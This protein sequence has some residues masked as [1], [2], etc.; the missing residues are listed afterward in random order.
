M[1][2]SVTYHEVI[3]VGPLSKGASHD[4]LRS[5]DGACPWMP[6]LP[7]DV[8]LDELR[9]V[10]RRGHGAGKGAQPPHPMIPSV[11]G[12]ED[13]FGTEYRL[14]LQGLPIAVNTAPLQAVGQLAVK[15]PGGILLVALS[16]S[17]YRYLCVRALTERSLNATGVL[18]EESDL[19]SVSLTGAGLEKAFSDY[20]EEYGRTDVGEKVAKDISDYIRFVNASF[21][22]YD[23]PNL[24]VG[25]CKRGFRFDTHPKHIRFI[26]EPEDPLSE[27]P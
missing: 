22:R 23:L 18:C 19:K 1:K 2:P 26:P 25:T 20:G 4:I 16:L 27:A 21:R 24:I 10:I 6:P 15:S 7:D 11:S 8:C 12:G 9:L 14:V 3:T 5:L 13:L 17:L